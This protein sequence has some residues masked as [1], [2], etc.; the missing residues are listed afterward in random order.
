MALQP[1][2]G[3][4][5]G[6]VYS[7][8]PRVQQRAEKERERSSCSRYSL[9][10]H[11]QADFLPLLSRLVLGDASVISFI[12]FLDVLY[13]QFRAILV[14]GVL[15]AR[16]KD[17]VVT[18]AEREGK[19]KKKKKTRGSRHKCLLVQLE[20]GLQISFSTR[21]QRAYRRE[22]GQKEAVCLRGDLQ[23]V[24]GRA[25]LQ[26]LRLNEAVHRLD[27]DACLLQF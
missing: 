11:V 27:D 16:F 1:D 19:K 21:R 24:H 13:Y 2:N 17:D 9:T 8:R 7:E 6:G 3:K 26:P 10:K 12:H 14:Q 22:G 23:R 18:V 4:S 25:V 20:K 5:C 15:I